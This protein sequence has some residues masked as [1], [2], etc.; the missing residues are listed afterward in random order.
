MRAVFALLAT[1]LLLLSLTNGPAASAAVSSEPAASEAVHHFEGDGDE[2]PSCPTNGA[3]HHHGS[4]CGGHQIAAPQAAIAVGPS[5]MKRPMVVL[6]HDF[7]PP[8]LDPAS[9]PKP[10]RA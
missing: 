3:V 10:P 2:V 1:C 4:S 9:E 7:L 6:A 8:G 5:V